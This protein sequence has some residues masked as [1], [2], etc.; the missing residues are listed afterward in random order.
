MNLERITPVLLTSN[1]EANI[2]RTLSALSWANEVIVL[3]SF[4][5]DR[6]ADICQSFKQVRFYQRMFTTHAEQWNAAIALAGTSWILSL[7]ADYLV[8]ESLIQE[9]YEINPASPVRGFSIPFLFAVKGT[10]LSAH[11]LPPRI[12]LFEKAYATYVQDGHTQEL[13]V[14][15]EISTLSSP[16]IHDDRKPFNRWFTAQIRYAELEVDK[17]TGTPYRKLSLQDKLRVL[18]L[19]APPAVIFY[20]LL[21]KRLIFEGPAGWTYCIHRFIAECVLSALLIRKFLA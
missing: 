13:R 2:Q 21:I 10:A 18:I 9:I 11:L 8:S 14:K 4:S 16:I 20:T 19:P 3:D 7:D 5:S 1:E 6:T 12:A 17:L 15:G